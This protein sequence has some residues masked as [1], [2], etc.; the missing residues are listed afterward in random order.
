MLTTACRT[1]G[2]KLSLSAHAV[3]ALQ[4]LPKKERW[5]SGDSTA[6]ASRPTLTASPR[7]VIAAALSVQGDS[8]ATH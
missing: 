6:S 8:H 7:A 3:G 2:V 5:P 4:L 1:H